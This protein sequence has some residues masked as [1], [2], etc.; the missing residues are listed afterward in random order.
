MYTDQ[1]GPAQCFL[2]FKAELFQ[3]HTSEIE[4][5]LPIIL[6]TIID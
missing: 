1:K 6:L 2:W 5:K 4:V 3:S